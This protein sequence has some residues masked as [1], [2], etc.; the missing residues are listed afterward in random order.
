MEELKI[1][2]NRREFLRNSIYGTISIIGLSKVDTFAKPRANKITILHT[3]DVHSHIEPFP[4]ND[5]KYPG[6]GG[7]ARRAALI[8]KIRSEEKDVLLLDAGDIYQGTYYFNKYGGELELKI[9]SQMGYDASTLGNHDFDNGLEGI[10]NK[11]EFANFPFL[12]ANYDFR[13]TIMEGKTNPYKIFNKSDVKIGVFG[14]GIELD[15]L[16][17][18]KNYGETKYLDPM[19]KAAETAIHLKKEKN[20]DVIICLSHLGFKYNE[21]KISDIEFAKQSRYIDLIIGGHTHTFLDKPVITKNR[22]GKE[23]CVA[24]VGW[25]GIKLGRIDLYFD[26]NTGKKRIEGS[27]HSLTKIFDIA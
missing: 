11:L 9:M 27:A 4:D 17:E 10:V 18:K 8:Q 21:R 23:T 20:C 26:K 13:G 24:Q 2:N 15:G 5:P 16:V 3:N 6:L 7:A 19:V 12:C 22:D 25:A 14:L 1:F